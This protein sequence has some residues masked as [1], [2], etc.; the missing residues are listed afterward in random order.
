IQYQKDAASVMKALDTFNPKDTAIVEEKD[1]I[2]DLNNLE[3]D[4]AASIQLVKNNNDDILYTANTSKKQLAVFSEIYYNLGWKA[5]IDNQ[6]APIV[7]VNYVLRGLVVPAGK[8]EIKFEFRP[9]SIDISKKASGIASILLW[10]FIIFVGYKA[11]KQ[12]EA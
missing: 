4:S 7:K 1:K 6:E 9:S 12:K 8:H 5:Y 11:L 2:A 10:G 3:V